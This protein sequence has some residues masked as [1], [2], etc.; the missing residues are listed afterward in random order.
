MLYIEY[1]KDSTK[2]LV[3]QMIKFSKVTGH[4]LS[5]HKLAVFGY[6]NNKVSEKKAM[7]TIPYTTASKRVK[8]LR[9]NL[10]KEVKLLYTQNYKTLMEEMEEDT[11]TWKEILYS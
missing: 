5:A 4:K 2:K 6:T 11:N 10:T 3:E 9:I 8:H 7:K 1:P